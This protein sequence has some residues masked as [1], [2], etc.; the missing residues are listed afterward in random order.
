MLNTKIPQTKPTGATA[1][2]GVFFQP[3]LTVS[4]PNDRYEQEADAMAD[5][6]M[7]MA[8]PLSG[9]ARFLSPAV[10]PVQRKCKHCEEEEKRQQ[11]QTGE[12]VQ[13]KCAK[14][15]E[16]EHVHRKE[17]GTA[18]PQVDEG[19]ENYVSSLGGRGQALPQAERSFFESRFNRDF[20]NVRIHADGGAA[21]S[22]QR[23]NARAYTTGDNI[24]FNAGQY[25]PGSEH[26]RRL[27]AHELT[28]VVQ[29]GGDGGLAED[30]YAER[31]IGGQ[32]VQCDL[33]IEPPNP[34][35]EPVALTAEEINEA[36]AYNERRFHDPY[37]I[38]NVRDVLGIPKYPAVIDA[39][40]VEA[41]VAWQVMYDLDPDGKMGA[42][43]TGT[44]LAE[45]R[46]EGA[47]EEADTLDVDNV[48]TT[49]DVV[50]RTYEVCAPGLPF[51]FN[52]QVAFRTTL[53]NGFIIQ[54]IDNAFN[55]QMCD[56]TAY[57]GW[58]PIRRYWEAWR[59]DGLG[60][61]RPMI[62]GVNDMFT[63]PLLPGSM[64]TWEMRGTI[65]TTKTLPAAFVAGSVADAGI[66][67][68]TLADPGDDFLGYVAARRRVGGRWGCCAPPAVHNPA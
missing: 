64:G 48:V 40:F 1:G 15:E 6:V 31:G 47:D 55:G 4:A 44:L 41:L 14:C 33:A 45:L 24:V 28:H 16:E 63:R 61:V 17:N 49:V 29:Q 27:L 59:V 26:G 20:S 68:A 37:N 42:E 9:D 54:R 51:E 32:I 46:A 67:R 23:I 52:W 62:S 12:R 19:F 25:Q 60:N 7:R 18:A 57:T 50:P 3:K 43:T 38:M 53:R 34:D 8:G 10:T 2:K 39:D 11:L 35:E 5:R 66:L 65:Y 21:Q 22:A 56:G 30:L 36:I 13:R 58:M